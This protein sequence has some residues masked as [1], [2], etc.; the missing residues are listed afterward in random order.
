M[1]CLTLTVL[2]RWPDRV[3]ACR[4]TNRSV[5]FHYT[6]HNQY[7]FLEK[8]IHTLIK[9][10]EMNKKKRTSNSKQRVE[11]P[12]LVPAEG[13]TCDIKCCLYFSPNTKLGEDGKSISSRTMSFKSQKS[14]LHLHVYMTYFRIGTIVGSISAALP[15]GVGIPFLERPDNGP[16]SCCYLHWRSRFQ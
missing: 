2:C 5:H 1:A 13:S 9:K 6:R 10:N 7:L 8:N 16:K 4:G 15:A 14:K 12:W 3:G 11:M